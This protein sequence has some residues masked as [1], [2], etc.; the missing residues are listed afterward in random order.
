MVLFPGPDVTSARSF[1]HR[2]LLLSFAAGFLAVTSTCHA[3]NPW[4][5]TWKLNYAKSK[6]T[7]STFTM[8]KSGSMY[9][10]HDGAIT[11]KFA[12]DG[13]DYPIASDYMIACQENGP[14]ATTMNKQ[15]G[16][17]LSTTEHEISADGK[18]MTDVTTG[19][20]PDGTPF[21]TTNVYTRVSGSGVTPVGTWRNTKVNATAPSVMA[22]KV[23]GDVLHS[24][25]PGYKSIV[26]AKLDGTPAPLN[27]P[28]VPAGLMIANKYEAPNKVVTT[29]LLNGKE[30]GKD[31][32]TIS[33]DGKTI[34]DVS[35]SPGKENEKQTYVYEKQ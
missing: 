10:M 15:K 13:K 33:A 24:E 27:G 12:C 6:L 8:E 1:M 3:A 32:M 34:T 11:Y 4:D 5:G 17:V 14:R 29:A 31:I 30:L 25:D 2:N 7:G 16:K 22:L 18:T 26:D 21:K 35:W 28:T 9:T 23:N 20:R 19:N